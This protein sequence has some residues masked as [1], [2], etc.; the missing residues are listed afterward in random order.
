[1][2][3]NIKYMIVNT[4]MSRQIKKYEIRYVS[5]ICTSKVSYNFSVYNLLVVIVVDLHKTFYTL[6]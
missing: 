5:A 3:K 6:T 2:Y 4:G 1:M